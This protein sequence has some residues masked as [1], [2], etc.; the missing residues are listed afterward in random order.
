MHYQTVGN[1][2]FP[3]LT[4]T[5]I[6]RSGIEPNKLIETLACS[7]CSL[8]PNTSA[9]RFATEPRIVSRVASS[10]IPSRSYVSILS[11]VEAASAAS[12]LRTKA[13]RLSRLWDLFSLQTV[14]IC[15]FTFVMPSRHARLRRVL[16]GTLKSSAIACHSLPLKYCAFALSH[17][18][19]VILR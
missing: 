7:P 9:E 5:S 8:Q 3:W 11:N 10:L 4:F 6:D 19:A 2:S 17:C 1:E 18:L 16:I 13:D 12:L 14:C 15:A